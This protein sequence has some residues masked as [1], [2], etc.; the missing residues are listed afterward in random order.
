MFQAEDIRETARNTLNSIMEELG[1]KFI[2][3]LVNDLNTI[4]TRGYQV[5]K[6]LEINQSSTA[7]VRHIL[8]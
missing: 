6:D 2:C 5:P 4:L 3:Y 8:G 7:I 1:P